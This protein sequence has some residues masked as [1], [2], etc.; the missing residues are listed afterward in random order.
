M[1]EKEG[2]NIKPFLFK[3]KTTFFPLLFF[4]Y[5]SNLLGLKAINQ[6]YKK[7]QRKSDNGYRF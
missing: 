2:L 1:K 6:E 7:C 3:K 4:A 5:S